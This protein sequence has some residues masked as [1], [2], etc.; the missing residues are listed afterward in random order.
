M[1]PQR[2][3]VECTSIRVRLAPHASL[4]VVG[5]AAL[6]A[7][8]HGRALAAC[9]LARELKTRGSQAFVDAQLCKAA[10]EAL[11]APFERG[12]AGSE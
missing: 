8:R 5:D 7:A 10:L 1:G 6:A 4:E 9:A 2:F 11:I 3:M 12:P